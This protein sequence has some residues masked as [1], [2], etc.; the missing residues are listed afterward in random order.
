[1]ENAFALRALSKPAFQIVEP[2]QS[3]PRLSLRRVLYVKFLRWVEQSTASALMKATLK[4]LTCLA[5]LLLV[6][7]PQFFLGLL[8]G[9]AHSSI[10]VR[11]I[12]YCA[13]LVTTLNAKRLY[14]LMRRHSV[15][16][17]KK[18]NN[19]TYHG[20][21][22]DNFVSYL[23]DNQGFTTK[24][25]SDLALSQRKWAKIADELEGAG[26]LVRG[27]SNARVLAEIDRATLARQLRDGFPLVFDPVSKTW[28][29]KR[30][31]F[32]TWVLAKERKEKKDIERVEKLER[33]ED[34]IRGR[35]AKLQQEQSGFQSVMALMNA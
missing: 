11:A 17:E 20:I 24:A 21:P 19:H 33:K 14:R 8:L 12:V 23:F 2:Q 1:M 6:S 15:S 18:G 10:T 28:C 4:C 31:S 27:E 3:H 16:K 35:I 22:L 29:E 7:A 9:A 5:L 13:V 32:D 34:N 25:I 26:V 30:G